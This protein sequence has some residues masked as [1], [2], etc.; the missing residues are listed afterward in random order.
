MDISDDPAA[1]LAEVEAEL[2]TSRSRLFFG[3]R[4]ESLYETAGRK[5][6][7]RHCVRTGALGLLIYNIFLL[8]DAQIIP[9]V[10]GLSIF[11]HLFVATPLALLCLWLTERGRMAPEGA[12]TTILLIVTL[13][14]VVLFDR[15]RAPDCVFMPI[16]LPLPVVFCAVVVRLPFVWTM[17]LA[18]ANLFLSMIAV[19]NHPDIHA[20]ARQ[21]LLMSDAAMVCFMLAVSYSAEASARQAYLLSLRD[22]LRGAVLSETNR[23]LRGISDTDALTGIG[24][25][26]FF[27]ATLERLW[28]AP[29]P[30]GWMLGLLMIDIDHFK[31]L[32]DRHGHLAGDV[33]LRAA[34]EAMRRQVRHE[35][36]HLARY[37]GEEFAVLLS[38]RSASEVAEI[39]ERIRRAVEELEIEVEGAS[40]GLSV[41]VSI[42]HATGAPGAG[43]LQTSLIAAADASLYTA[44]HNG[45]NRIHPPLLRVV[46]NEPAIAQAI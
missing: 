43:A 13:I 12:T 24:N 35:G 25:R 6:F 3:A 5:D 33:C 17:M 7:A 42:G 29:H 23:R 41:T 1:M 21:Y 36:D 40:A 27:D 39:A 18:A 45:R 19:S 15:S 22:S 32:N 30:P 2:R 9:D 34:A 44:K 37:G 4:L 28:T 16:V 38:N 8:S 20:A 11:L 26:R 10:M 46:V 31:R 14:M